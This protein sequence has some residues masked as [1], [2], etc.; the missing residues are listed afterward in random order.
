RGWVPKKEAYDRSLKVLKFLRD[1]MPHHHGHFFHFIDMRTG[2]RV[3][4]SEVSNIDTA[5]L[6]GGVLC[7]R[8]YFPDTDLAK[9]AD[10]LYQRVDWPWLMDKKLGGL[11]C[12]GWKPESDTLTVVPGAITTEVN[13]KAEGTFLTAHWGAYS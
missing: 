2:E 9:V 10:E 5:L 12:M 13:H 8:Q 4:N 6:M 11:M 1:K 7:V 3:W